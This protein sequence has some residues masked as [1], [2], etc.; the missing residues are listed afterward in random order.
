MTIKE[1]AEKNNCTEEVI[2]LIFN[3]T[4]ELIQ[5]VLKEKCE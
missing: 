2:Y 4:E 3:L 1:L 5:E